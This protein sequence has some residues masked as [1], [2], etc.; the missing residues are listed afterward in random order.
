MKH[1]SMIHVNKMIAVKAA[2]HMHKLKALTSKLY[3]YA[4]YQAN[5]FDIWKVWVAN[6]L[7]GWLFCM[8]KQML[9]K[10]LKA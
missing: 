8:L 1:L 9:K 2:F 5:H 10:Y 3:V 7:D 4:K 6:A